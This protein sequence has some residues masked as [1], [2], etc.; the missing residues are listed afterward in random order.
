MLFEYCAENF[1]NIEAALRAGADRIELC[2]HLAPGGT[3]PTARGI[4]PAGRDGGEPQGAPRHFYASPPRGSARILGISANR[5]AFNV[6]ICA[7]SRSRRG[8][9]RYPGGQTFLLWGDLLLFESCAETFTNIEAALRAGADR[10]ELCDNLA[11]GGTTPSA[12]VIEQAVR[13]VR[14]HEGAELRVIIRPRRGN[15]DYSKAEMR[16]M[17]TDIRYA[18]ANG[19]DGVVLGC[20]KRRSKVKGFELDLI[21]GDKRFYFGETFCCSNLAPRPS[22]ISRRPCVPVPIASSCATTSPRAAPRRPPA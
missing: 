15:F 20:L 18:G 21:L 2:D 17:E 3:T 10:I 22:P 14:E 6:A 9:V 4:E 19:V 5:S 8:G 12:G 1:T 16:A 11:Q 7:C 13:I